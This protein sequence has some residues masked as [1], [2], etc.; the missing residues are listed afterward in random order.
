MSSGKQ[1]YIHSDR[2]KNL[3]DY[4]LINKLFQIEV[5]E[6]E[7]YNEIKEYIDKDDLIKKTIKLIYIN[8]SMIESIE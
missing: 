6:S 4:S 2:A 7:K 5:I 8:Y 1:Y 3:A